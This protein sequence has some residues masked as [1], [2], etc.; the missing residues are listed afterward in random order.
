MNGGALCMSSGRMVDEVK[1][2]RK[3]TLFRAEAAVA[4]AK[5]HD[6]RP[7]EQ[8]SVISYV[9]VISVAIYICPPPLTLLFSL[10][11]L[12]HSKGSP[13]K[14]VCYLFTYTMGSFLD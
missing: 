3:A 14:G 12:S 13:P 5:G 9:D 4:K 7:A 6:V 10:R 1:A 2:L 8:K 11:L